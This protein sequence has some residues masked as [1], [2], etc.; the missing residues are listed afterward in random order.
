MHR[1][2][3]A[4]YPWIIVRKEENTSIYTLCF[5]EIKIPVNWELIV[6]GFFVWILSSI[7]MG[8]FSGLYKWLLYGHVY[9]ACISLPSNFCQPGRNVWGNAFSTF[10]NFCL[11]CQRCSNR[12]KWNVRCKKTLE[13]GG[14]GNNS[15]VLWRA[16]KK[17]WVLLWLG[18][19]ISVNHDV[20]S[21]WSSLSEPM[22][23]YNH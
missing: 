10:G 2:I 23:M 12:T 16:G 21:A 3:S 20:Q 19:W 22:K 8:E 14:V 1:H 5:E 7:N 4:S 17:L 6:I 11:I 9:K 13:N 18:G 15:W